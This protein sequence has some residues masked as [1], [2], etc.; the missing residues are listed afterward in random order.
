MATQSWRAVDIRGLTPAIDLRRSQELYVL[1][2]RNFIFDSF[3]PKS[4]FGN[5]LLSST[6][7]SNPNHLQG[8][9]IQMRPRDRVFI[10]ASN[11]ILEWDEFDQ[12]YSFIYATP[13]T[14]LQPY[15]WTAGY[16]NEKIYFCHPAVGLL[17]LDVNA[18]VCQPLV[19]AGVPTEAIACCIDNGRLCV[20]DEI[21]EYWS[22]QSDGSNFDPRL[23]G[24][25]FQKIADRVAGT[26]IMIHSYSRG[27][28]VFTTGGVMQSEFTGDVSVYR[29][30]SI[31][32]EYRPINSF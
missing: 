29:H 4:A 31:N 16:L 21:A 26:P 20:I 30:R 27:T 15:R 25:G 5:R 11:G 12:E 19:G 6:V 3:G 13:D 23:G 17:V 7:F 1:G 9:R 2:G 8:I 10:F 28:L 22:A 32:T 14:T 18:D 24:A